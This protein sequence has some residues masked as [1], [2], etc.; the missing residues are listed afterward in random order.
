M[1]RKRMTDGEIDEQIR[2]IGVGETRLCG[3]GLL[4]TV[5]AIG[6]HVYRTPSRGDVHLAR[7]I[8]AALQAEPL[9]E[10]LLE[11]DIVGAKEAR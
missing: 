2:G 11:A 6:R 7:R 5:D 3:N 4:C 10:G 1:K 9:E 8:R